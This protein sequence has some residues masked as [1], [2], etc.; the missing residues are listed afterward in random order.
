M[1]CPACRAEMADG[2]TILPYQMEA[3]NFI[4]VTGVPALICKQC[5]EEYIELHVVRQLEH[6]LAKIQ[7]DGVQFGVVSYEQAA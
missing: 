4:V 1:E 2:K 6:I 7:V 3:G 5:G